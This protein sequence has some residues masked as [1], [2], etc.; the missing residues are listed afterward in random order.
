MKSSLKLMHRH[1]PSSSDYNMKR[2]VRR[3]LHCFLC[4]WDR[5]W[6]HE[7]LPEELIIDLGGLRSKI[8]LVQLLSHF[9]DK[10]RIK[11]TNCLIKSKIFSV[12]LFLLLPVTKEDENA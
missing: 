4:S 10:I 9:L 2:G 1:C 3:N 8:S 7:W 5:N 12:K 11:N 6:L